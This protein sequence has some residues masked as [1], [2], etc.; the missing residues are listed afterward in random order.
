MLINSW[1]VVG[2]PTPLKNIWVSLSIGI[3]F[4]F[5]TE[6]KIIFMFQTTN[7]PHVFHL[8]VLVF[9]VYDGS[10]FRMFWWFLGYNI[11]LV[12]EPTPQKNIWVKVNWNDDIPNNFG[13]QWKHVP[14]RQPDVVIGCFDGMEMTWRNG[15]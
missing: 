9:K 6:W 13:E 3:M 7:Q 1:L 14:N 8:Q 4:P 10:W 12:V 15:F 5:P 2:I 11:F